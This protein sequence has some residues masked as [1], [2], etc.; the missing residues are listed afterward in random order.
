MRIQFDTVSKSTKDTMLGYESKD[1]CEKRKTDLYHGMHLL[2]RVYP[3][4]PQMNPRRSHFHLVRQAIWKQ[5]LPLR[6]PMVAG[7][8]TEVAA[9]WTGWGSQVISC[10]ALGAGVVQAELPPAVPAFSF[11]D[12]PSA[13]PVPPCGQ[14]GHSSCFLALVWP[15]QPWLLQLFQ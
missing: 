5:A 13:R 4:Y 7:T 9:I 1:Q 15:G 11:A 8:S 14:P 2:Y 6:R 3:P 10:L 12:G